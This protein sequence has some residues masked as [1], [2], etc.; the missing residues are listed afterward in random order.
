MLTRLELVFNQHLP[1]SSAENQRYKLTQRWLF[2]YR[3]R[4][5]FVCLT[6]GWGWCEVNRTIREGPAQ[7]AGY[8]QAQNKTQ[9]LTSTY[10]PYLKHYESII[11]TQIQ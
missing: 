2:R 1:A 9:V 11:D 10:F 5:K 7:R 6:Q 8:T 4:C 3:K